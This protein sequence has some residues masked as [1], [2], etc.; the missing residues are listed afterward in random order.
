MKK[1]NSVVAI[2][3]FFL[4]SFSAHAQEDGQQMLTQGVDSGSEKKYA[5]RVLAPLDD[6]TVIGGRMMLDENTGI[7]VDFAFNFA[8][9]T[10]DGELEGLAL[11][12]TVAYF[13]YFD[14]G[15]V[16]PYYKAGVNLSVH[17]DDKDF[18][19][20]NNP[21]G[22][23]DDITLAAGIGAEFFVIPE[24]SLYAEGMLAIAFSPFTID[25]FTPRA[26][27]AFYF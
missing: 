16:S 25:T 7:D 20:N 13:Q 4:A 18:S 3:T 5:L 11:D 27:L 17:T 21:D 9:D 15:R 14:K 23:D 2:A 6:T 19:S 22:G 8:S 10:K 1:I 12:T 26:G 24:F